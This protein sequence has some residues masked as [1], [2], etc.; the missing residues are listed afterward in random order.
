MPERIGDYIGAKIP[1]LLE[2]LENK[3]Q[4]RDALGL[5]HVQKSAHAPGR[6]GHTRP[7][8]VRQEE[9]AEKMRAI[10]DQFHSN[11]VFKSEWDELKK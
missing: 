2:F 6:V 10:Q 3:I 5:S 1:S 4:T 8:H 11:V 7:R 9:P